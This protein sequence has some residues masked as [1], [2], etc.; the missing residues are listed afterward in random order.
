MG[1][2]SIPA[3]SD[4][5]DSQRLESATHTS[6][7]TYALSRV[8]LVGFGLVVFA[9]MLLE[10]PWTGFRLSHYGA[11]GWALSSSSPK[12]RESKRNSGLLKAPSAPNTGY[13]SLP[14]T[15]PS[16]TALP[17]RI[18]RL[19]IALPTYIV[20]RLNL[21]LAQTILI[22]I[23]FI[24]VIIAS[25]TNSNWLT[26]STRTGY[27]AIT[28][29]P[30]VI[31]LGNKV[32][33]VGTFLSVG[34]AAINWAHRWLGRILFLITTIHVIAYITIFVQT[35][36]FHEEMSKPANVLATVSYIG[37]CF[38]FFSSIGYVRRNWWHLF[39]ATHHLGVFLF[40]IGLNYHSTILRPW[41]V[42]CV[43]VV[44][45][46]V[47]SR[48]LTSRLHIA[49]VTALPN[50]K[51]TIVHFP[52]IRGGWLPG[53]HVRIRVL[54]GGMPI[55]T[56]WE[57]HPFTLASADSQGDGARLVVKAAGNWTNSL[58]AIAKKKTVAGKKAEGG[59][60]EIG[61]GKGYPMAVLIEGPYGGSNLVYSAY[62]SVLL[63]AGGSGVSYVLGV[64]N[65][66]VA[67]SKAGKAATRTLN[68]VWTV[69]D[70][71]AINDLLPLFEEVLDRARSVPQLRVIITLYFTS[72]SRG[73]IIRPFSIMPTTS[74]FIH[75]SS[76]HAVA[77][78]PLTSSLTPNS[79]TA[80]LLGPGNSSAV[81]IASPSPNQGVRASLAA[82]PQFI[83]GRADDDTSASGEDAY[84]GVAPDDEKMN[85]FSDVHVPQP[86]SPTTKRFHYPRAS[87]SSPLRKEVSASHTSYPGEPEPSPP[88]ELK[89][90]RPDYTKILQDLIMDE[91]AR[92]R[93]FVETF[94]AM[95][96]E[97]CDNSS[98]YAGSMS[99]VLTATGSSAGRIAVGACGPGGMVASLRNLCHDA[100]G[101]E[102]HADL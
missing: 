61:I 2:I 101:V 98:I 90:G 92:A 6:A 79:S 13:P 77:S 52:S 41:V 18:G 21:S 63:A 96:P 24:L 67:D 71:A 51:S 29:V 60:V 99:A 95:N 45:I 47:I 50:T 9:F 42:F 59:D 31:T 27:I 84:A 48:I 55:E 3:G 46:S 23:A 44:G 83:I 85:P 30:C 19:P 58:F 88:I 102:F 78:S 81:D 25:F 73:L 75:Q 43:V 69:R 36:S 62:A 100:D 20:P 57:G 11:T 93:S 17:R 76:S 32:F 5:S 12:R 33:G 14:H 40:I 39:K 49:Y 26:D 38:I 54:T 94:R 89:P 35:H 82:A 70:R 28:L 86:P 87:E 74:M 91:Q 66:I 15:R 34:Y 22:G 65:A 16:F 53:Q 72:V 4:T 37:F 80:A 56:L 1:G 10:L 8:I 68:I 97:L 7:E 64:A